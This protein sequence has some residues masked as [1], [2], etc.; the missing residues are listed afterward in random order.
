MSLARP[1]RPDALRPTADA[2]LGAWAERVRAEREQV[3]RCREVED[4]ADFYA[5]V[6]EH[7]R[8]D[9]RRTG[10]QLLDRLLAHVRPGEVWLDIGAGGGRFSLPI[11]RHAREVLCV[12]PSDGML[13]VLR[14]GMTEHGI[15][16]VRPVKGRWPLPSFERCADVAFISHVGYDIEEIGPF[17]D[18][19]EAAA[20]RACVAV[21]SEGAMTT[22]A[23]LFWQAVH[24]EAR[25]PLPALPEFLGLLMARGRLPAVE[26]EERVPS[27]FDSLEELTAM[28]RRQLWVRPGS[29]RDARL[30][31]LVRDMASQR[32][33]RWAL[34]WS[35]ARVGVVAWE[36]A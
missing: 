13:A 14:E 20:R 8:L 15:R 17:L 24:G 5:P 21:F 25:V 22:A 4:P 11:A 28:A 1:A 18:G 36:P 33:G 27:T 16:N 30:L 31:G 32:D 12:D 23:T 26:L 35:R 2:A 6:A 9:P 29:V 19:M 34:D 7:F 3:H 10:D